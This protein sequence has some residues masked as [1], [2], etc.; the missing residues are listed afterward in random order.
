MA[1][2][3]EFDYEKPTAP[4]LRKEYDMAALLGSMVDMEDEEAPFIGGIYGDAGSGKTYTTMELAQRMTPPDMKI[5]YVFTGQGWTSLKND[6]RLMQRVKK[7]QYVDFDQIRALCESLRNPKFRELTK[8][9][10]VVFDEFNTMFDLNVE[11]ITNINSINIMRDKGKYKDPDTP[12]W[13]E[14]NTGKNHMINLMNDVLATPDIN[15]YFVCHP[16]MGKKSYKIEP[17]FFDK[18]SQAFLRNLHSLYYLS[19]DDSTGK[20]ER[21]I[22]LQGNDQITAKNRIAPEKL[23]Q[24]STTKEIS[25]A[26]KVWSAGKKP[27]KILP[28]N[29]ESP[30]EKQEPEKKP[31]TSLPEPVQEPKVV[32]DSLDDMFASMLD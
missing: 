23:G 29:D 17:D 25:D 19:V 20:V 16:R 22:M 26:F 30:Q 31:E 6:P 13:P 8:I 18:A 4:I 5:V 10:A 2:N 11:L 15:F 7:M 27:E 1:S 28:P 32:A 14:Y 9:G 24:Y 3:P 12:E 21:R